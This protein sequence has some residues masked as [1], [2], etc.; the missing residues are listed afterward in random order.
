GVQRAADGV[1]ALTWGAGG[2]EAPQIHIGLAV[3]RALRSMV[4]LVHGQSRLADPGRAVYGGDHHRAT[5]LHAGV[6]EGCELAE[7]L[8]PAHKVR[9]VSGKLIGGPKRRSED[10]GLAV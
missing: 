2:V 4:G 5:V 9:G 6:E 10:V 3:G 1:R 8:V 7:F